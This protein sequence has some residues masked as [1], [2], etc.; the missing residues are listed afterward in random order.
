MAIDNCNII[1][2]LLPSYIDGIC[3]ED[4]RIEV[5]AHLAKCDHC[6]NIY[7]EMTGT[8][9]EPVVIDDAEMKK[10]TEPFRKINTRYHIKVLLCVL[11][12]LIL[13]GMVL[14]TFRPGII[15][16][17]LKNDPEYT[18]K[19]Y[20]RYMNELKEYAVISYKYYYEGNKV[21]DIKLNH[22]S[23]SFYWHTDSALNLFMAYDII[24]E[25][26]TSEEKHGSFMGTHY[27]WGYVKWVCR[28]IEESNYNE[29]N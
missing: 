7:N 19:I 10:V 6:R 21:V 28:I 27:L 5:E 20:D 15:N 9:I 2:D 11:A 13:M 8:K 4:S 17:A 26:G 29:N 16:T 18:D 23:K 1:C 14:S 24:Y 25:D 12:I 3:S 22:D